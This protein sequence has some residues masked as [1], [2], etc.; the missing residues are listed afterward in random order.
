MKHSCYPIGCSM[1]YWTNGGSFHAQQIDVFRY[2]AI[3]FCASC[4]VLLTAND[5]SIYNYEILSDLSAN[6]VYD[7][8]IWT[9]FSSAS[10]QFDSVILIDICSV[11]DAVLLMASV[12]MVW[13]E[14]S[15]WAHLSLL[16]ID[17]LP[18]AHSDY[19]YGSWTCCGRTMS[20][21]L[22]FHSICKHCNCMWQQRHRIANFACTH[23][24]VR[25]P[26][27]QSR[28]VDFF[29]C[30]LSATEWKPFIKRHSRD[31]NYFGNHLVILIL[32]KTDRNILYFP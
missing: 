20:S 30:R 1:I 5:E 21:G 4:V 3:D 13:Q 2:R 28:S 29:R 24:L 18:R 15:F 22:R 17:F 11:G 27:V 31:I 7:W 12:W 8:V 32:T 14:Q 6:I 16:S 19:R 23:E 25:Q 10:V 9:D 26:Y